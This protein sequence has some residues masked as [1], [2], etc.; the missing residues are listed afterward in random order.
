MQAFPFGAVLVGLQGP[1]WIAGLPGLIVVGV[2]PWEGEGRVEGL[3]EAGVGH[4]TPGLQVAK[5]EV[6]AVQVAFPESTAPKGGV[7]I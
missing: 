7:G 2:V 3:L 5:I 1:V 4:H 6:P